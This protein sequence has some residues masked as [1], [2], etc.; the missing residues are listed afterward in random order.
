[1]LRNEMVAFG[2]RRHA[3]TALGLTVPDRLIA[4]ANEVIE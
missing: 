4:L 1:M 3:G 2:K